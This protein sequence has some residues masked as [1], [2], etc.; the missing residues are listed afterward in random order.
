MLV[1]LS[2]AVDSKAVTSAQT[3]SKSF[4]CPWERQHR[5]FATLPAFCDFGGTAM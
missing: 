4:T 3:K 2:D 5:A 1:L